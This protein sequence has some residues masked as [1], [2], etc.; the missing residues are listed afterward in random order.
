MKV[1]AMYLPQF[2]RTKENDEWWGEGY[3]DWVAVKN[4][5]KLFTNHHEP[6]VPLNNNYYNLLEKEN[7]SWQAEHMSKYN[8]YGMCFYHYWFKDGK[9]VLEKPAENLLKWKNINM[10][11]CFSWANETWARSWSKIS[12]KNTRF[13]DRMNFQSDKMAN[14]TGILLEQSYGDRSDWEKHFNYLVNFFK[15][16]RYIKIEN[17]P[18]FIIYK[19]KLI[20]CFEKMKKL[21]NDLARKNGFKGIYFIATNSQNSENLYDAVMYQQPGMV[22]SQ[23]Y[24]ESTYSEIYPLKKCIDYEDMW[25]K[26]IDS[27]SKKVEKTYF[28]GVVGYDDSP[29]RGKGGTGII[30]ASPEIL[31]KYFKKL[32]KINE[33]NN[34]EYVFL[35]AWNEWG[36]GMY[37]EPDT[38]YEFGYLQAVKEAMEE[39]RNE[40]IEVNSNNV[41]IDNQK[42]I[43]RYKGYW[44]ILDEWLSIKED[45]KSVSLYLKKKNITSI[46]IYGVGMLGRHLIKEIENSD[47]VIKYCVDRY[48]DI[49]DNKYKI[50]GMDEKLPHADAIIIT[51]TYDYDNIYSHIIKRFDGK[52]ISLD[53]LI[54]S[55]LIEY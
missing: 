43:D 21:W 53:D 19:P 25:N 20:S 28:G 48:L 11:F 34:V 9:Q 1:I 37:M 54:H 38:S 14:D 33:N 10:P 39:Y 5:D 52:I 44:K 36:E 27:S 23:Y 3:T 22:I 18:I 17:K 42:T 4:A 13:N 16:E 15:D 40:L 51:A 26:I 24:T 49:V 47:I 2:Y 6:R 8:V 45:K 12:D 41:V 30:N 7:M 29:R 50:Y 32:I 31:K 55:T 46:A 35:N